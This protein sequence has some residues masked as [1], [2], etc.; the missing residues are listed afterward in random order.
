MLRVFV[1]LGKQMPKNKAIVEDTEEVARLLAKYNCTMVQGGAKM[2]LMGV[3][4]KGFEKYSDQIV[5]IVPEIH[6]SD[7]DG[8]NIDEYYIVEGESDRMKITIRTCDMMIVLPGGSGTLAELSYYNETCKSGEHDAKVVIVNT[9]GFYNKL[10]K[11]HKHQIKT[12]FMTE[13]AC[14]Y[15]VISSAKQLEPILQQ[16]IKQKQEQL[17]VE[18][19]KEEK[20]AVVEEAK[21]VVEVKPAKKVSKPKKAGAKSA[22]VTSKKEKEE[23]KPVKKAKPKIVE[24]KKDATKVSSKPAKVEDVKTEL[25]VASKPAK[26]AVAKKPAKETKS[27]VPVTAK[28]E[29]K[30]V[31]K[32]VKPVAK[33]VEKTQAKTEPKS[34]TKTATPKVEKVEA[35][36]EVKTK[37]KS[38]VKPKAKTSAK[39]PAAKSAVKVADKKEVKPV[40]KTVKKTTKK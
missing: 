2:G 19:A 1:A 4:V 6:K 37:A 39:K 27:V 14:R 28:K 30:E 40:S 21:E 15:E 26:K 35:K 38:E 36:A 3:V 22:K 29:V 10:F 17:N 11:F 18:K 9:K 25:K 32:S 31:K 8:V 13:D 5:M 33:K 24:T 23:V 20:L 12:G 16:L 34:K 7:L